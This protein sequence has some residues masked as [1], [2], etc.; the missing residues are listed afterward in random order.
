MVHSRPD[1]I[2]F[3]TDPQLLGLAISPA[4]ETLLRAFYALPLSDDQLDLF[5]RCTGRERPSTT[6]YSELT[7]IAG[8]RSGKDSRIAAP[9][10]LYES[11][12]GRHELHLGKG[13][14]GV[15]PLVAQDKEATRVAYTYLK[16]YLTRA[17]LLSTQ[18]ADEPLT[19]AL[20]LT[21]GL[22]IQCFPC[23]LRSLRGWSIPVGVLDE[24]AFFRLEGAADSD[25][26]IQQ[27]VRRGMVSFPGAKLV[28]VSTPYM[29]GGVVYADFTAAYGVDHPDLLVW[30]AATALMN[31]ALTQRLERERR[32]DPSRYAREYEAEFADD[33]SAFL[34]AQWIDDAVRPGRYELAPQPGVQ[35]IA[36]VD[37]SGGGDDSF[38]LSICHAVGRGPSATV[39]QSAVKGWQRTGTQA[40]VLTGVVK[41]IASLLAGYGIRTVYGDRYGG[42]WPR[43]AFEDAGLVYRIA[44]EVKGPDGKALYQDK[45]DFYREVE[46]LFS[47]GRLELLDHERQTREF[48]ILE[49]RPRAGGKV[50]VDHPPRSHDDHANSLAIA[51]VLALRE[52][53]ASRC[54]WCGGDCFP[55]CERRT[56]RDPAEEARKEEQVAAERDAE[57]AKNI[58][59]ACRRNGGYFF[60]GDG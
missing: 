30:K 24:L 58:L 42:R 26:E 35:Y 2:E 40:P 23:T 60:P 14:R 54:A 57:V 8:A 59:S 52:V 44:T 36:G 20:T 29:K 38:T 43:Q 10:A 33:V 31:P 12:F 45:S 4:Q 16:D 49:S 41:E 11:L 17:P 56:A 55:T 22:T 21:N 34:P 37:P 28:K 48:K 50:V 3:V 53:A 27:S 13:E 1:I 47:Q 32:L 15:I 9:I 51:A 5:R 6:P 25:A 39:V 7:V 19:T 18:L 46:P